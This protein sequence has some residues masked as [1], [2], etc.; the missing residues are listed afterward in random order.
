MRDVVVVIRWRPRMRCDTLPAGPT[1][2]F[3]EV[4]MLLRAL[5]SIPAVVPGRA[6][7]GRLTAFG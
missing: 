4:T 7:E 2:T 1:P 3:E 6:I 5:S